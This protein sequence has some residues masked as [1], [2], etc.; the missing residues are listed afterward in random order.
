MHL[1]L[2]CLLTAFTLGSLAAA[3]LAVNALAQGADN[4]D[5]ATGAIPLSPEEF[6][7]LPHT[8]T[9]RAFLPAG[10]DLSSRL[11][12]I[13]NQKGQESCVAW[14]VGYAAR[15]Y[16]V[17]AMES[18]DVRN[19]SNIPSPAFIYNSIVEPGHCDAGSQISDALNLLKSGVP[20]ERQVPYD[21]R[22]CDRPTQSQLALPA[23]FACA[24]GTLSIRTASIKSRVSSPKAT[25]SW[26]RSTAREL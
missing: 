14:A 10:V 9:Y 6:A 20:S 15:A 26:C 19:K 16:Y 2:R 7:R 11:P 3:G 13:G 4:P 12:P 17:A 18:R 24:I 21:A 23:I 8:P 1:Y 5:F 22:R 25:R